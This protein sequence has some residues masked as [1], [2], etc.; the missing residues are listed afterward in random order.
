M[1][2]TSAL[3]FIFTVPSTQGHVITRLDYLYSEAKEGKGSALCLLFL[4]FL[5]RPCVA[6]LLDAKL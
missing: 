4:L 6:K 3:C 1:L 2:V 5:W